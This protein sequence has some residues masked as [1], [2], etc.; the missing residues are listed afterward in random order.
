MKFS[1]CTVHVRA[2][3]H[4]FACVKDVFGAYANYDPHR[5]FKQPAGIFSD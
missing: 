2:R 4:H 5:R 1:M 3:Y